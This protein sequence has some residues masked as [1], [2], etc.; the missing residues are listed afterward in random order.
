MARRN[1]D[2]FEVGYK[3]LKAKKKLKPAR[4]RNSISRELNSRRR[5]AMLG[6]A[7]Q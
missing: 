7:Y 5:H 1:I 2:N 3:P 6:L 4:G